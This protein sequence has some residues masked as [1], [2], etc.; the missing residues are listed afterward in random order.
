MKFFRLILLL[1]LVTAWLGRTYA[2]TDT[3]KVRVN[4]VVMASKDSIKKNTPDSL[5]KKHDPRKA[6]RRS[7]MIPGWGQ[8]Y[9]REYWKI[10]LVYGALAIPTGLFFYNNNWYTKTKFAY[11][12]KYKAEVYKDSSNYAAIDPQ[13]VGL[14]S[15]SLQSYRNTFRRDRDYSI[16]FFLLAWG[17]NVVDATV[18]GH[19]KDFD[20]SSDL[21]MNVKPNLNPTTRTP[22]LTLTFSPKKPA[23]RLYEV[24]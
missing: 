18:F 10:P 24:R 4:S 7:A 1:F 2:Q 5:I 17:L 16:L 3:S 21:S 8:A 6:T 9:N 15:A 13:L 20:V 19:L 12:A 14:S 23:H 22:G 11:E